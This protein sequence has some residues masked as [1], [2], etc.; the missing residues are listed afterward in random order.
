MLFL[1]VGSREP[2]FHSKSSRPQIFHLPAEE[3]LTGLDSGIARHLAQARIQ[4]CAARM[5]S[6]DVL[7]ACDHNI[8]LPWTVCRGGQEVYLDIVSHTPYIQG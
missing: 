8:G 2:G 5:R 3:A 4:P 6:I 7:P 1:M